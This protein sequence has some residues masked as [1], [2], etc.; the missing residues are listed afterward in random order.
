MRRMTMGLLCGALAAATVGAGAAKAEILL[1][2]T[3]TN[4]A[5]FGGAS[6]IVDFNGAD[7]GGTSHTFT[8]G[9]ANT[10]VVLMFNAECAVEGGTSQWLDVDILVD[11]AGPTAESAAP[12]SNGDNAFCSGN[13]TTSGNFTLDGWVSAVTIATINLPQAGTHTVRVRVNSA[14]TSTLARLDDMSLVVMR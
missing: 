12:P 5:V 8:T 13:G 14:G 6:Y 2:R 11:P 9:A 7:A 1:T 4:A 10:R 3:N